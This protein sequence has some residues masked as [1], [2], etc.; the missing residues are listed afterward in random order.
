MPSIARHIGPYMLASMMAGTALVTGTAQAQEANPAVIDAVLA[1]R[2]IEDAAQ[3]LDCL[4][5]A[6]GDLATAM[7]R[8]DL[9]AVERRQAVAAEREGFGLAFVNPGRVLSSIVGR[10]T[11]DG[12]TS[13]P[14]VYEDGAEA[15]RN[16][17]GEIDTLRG[18]P[19]RHVAHDHYG[20]LVVTL[21]NGHV[22]RQTDSRRVPL[23]RAGQPVTLELRR[24]TLGSFFMS[25]STSSVQVRAQRD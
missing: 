19:V 11:T 21:E 12:G 8:Q 18:I 22:W 6:T 10:S 25:L 5:R 4:D 3:R 9:V 20:K 14:E 15:I 17:S 1:C 7:E 23:P 16:Q 2:S 13:G 24:G